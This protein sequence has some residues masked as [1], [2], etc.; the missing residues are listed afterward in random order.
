VPSSPGLKAR[1]EQ[2]PSEEHMMSVVPSFDLRI[3]RH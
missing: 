1:L 3:V 2:N